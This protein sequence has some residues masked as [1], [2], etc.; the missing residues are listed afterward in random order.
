MGRKSTKT[1]A[2]CDEIADRVSCGEPLAVVCRS[3]NIGYRTVYDWVEA[4]T[5]FAANIARARLTGHDV[6]AA[7]CL[8]IADDSSNDYMDKLAG[9]DGHD[10][11]PQRVFDAEHVQRS[12]LR[13]ETRLKLLAKWDKRY[14]DMTVEANVRGTVSYKANLPARNKPNAEN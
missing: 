8:A 10:G 5:D 1:Q 3:M 13:I 12:K 11:A 2:L 7:D 14:G 9:A 6:I 4:D